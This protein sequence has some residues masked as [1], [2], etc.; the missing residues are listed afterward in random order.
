MTRRCRRKTSSANKS[1]PPQ[2]MGK[3]FFRGFIAL[4]LIAA[5]AS[6]CG[7]V[8]LRR[9]L[10][11]KE[12]HGL[13]VAQAEIY[14]G[15]KPSL[16]PLR[17]DGF[18]VNV[19]NFEA[20]SQGQAKGLAMQ[21]IKTGI[22]AG[23]VAR[24]VWS[25]LP[26]RV[27]NLS[28]TW[29]ATAKAPPPPQIVEEQTLPQPMKKA[30][31]D[32]WIPKQIETDTLVI[33]NSDLHLIL[34]QGEA[35]LNG[36]RWELE[37]TKGFEN[38]KLSGNGGNL[39]LPY[40]WAPAMKLDQLRFTYHDGFLY[41]TEATLSAYENG[42]VKL[43]GE[44]DPASRFYAIEGS[45]RDVL[46]SEVLPPDWKQRLSGVI[47]SSF[48]V[49]SR[50]SSA[51]VKGHVKIH[52]GIL[53][54]LPVLDKL[55]A[56]SQSL[57]F[58]TL[59]LH[60]AEADYEITDEGVTLSNVTIGSEGLARME[61]KIRFLN[62]NLNRSCALDGDFR[63]GLAPGT[64]ATIPG[65]EE[66]VFVQ[67]E[68]GLMWAPMHISGTLDNPEEDLS[69]RLM[70]AAGARMF[71][72]I[73]AT[74]LKV[75]KYTQQVVDDNGQETMEKVV[76][77]TTDVIDQTIKTS[78]DAIGGVSKAVEGVFGIFGGGPKEPMKNIPSPPIP[79]PQVA[80]PPLPIPPVPKP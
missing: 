36:T 7:Y 4:L 33:S 20:E 70:S 55:A 5:I 74:G 3:F 58:R 6:V 18:R 61:G 43:S 73:P 69:G 59:S 31:Y 21:G 19:E 52:Q 22:D 62:N 30:W 67:G 46:C 78:N 16:S 57:R 34:A 75:L 11:S 71:D 50:Q 12:F 53:T 35:R 42:H 28:L 63:V 68:R 79:T 26:S 72:M 29:D 76:K 38:C 9:Y 37:P 2:W 27:T 64:L 39:K 80:K 41:L 24:G 60:D 8:W 13:I 47:E 56:Y 51:V 66:D 14:L 49:Q 1:S 44:F 25:V 32:R 77:K 65:A 45:L 17:W 40:A 48:S 15:A 10:S 23:G 54:A